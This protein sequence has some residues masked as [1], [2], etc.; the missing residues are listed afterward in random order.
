M[1][2][3]YFIG[4]DRAKTSFHC[5]IYQ[6]H[7]KLGSWEVDNHKQ[8]LRKLEKLLK[9][10]KITNKDQ[11][12]FGL[13]HTG[14]YNHNLLQWIVKK[15]YPLWLASPLAI[16]K[17]LGIQRGKSDQVDAQR[18]A[19][20]AARLADQAQLWQPAREVIAELKGL[21]RVRARLLEAR[22]KLKTPLRERSIFLSA[23]Q[24][25]RLS[26]CCASSL[27]H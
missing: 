19:Q 8:G 6:Q 2:Y 3:K 9:E 12:L 20:Y 21:V 11:A 17:S 13:A 7:N 4:I 23:A 5:C 18:I 15:G 16:K 10:L 27:K 22:H 26:C 14:V 25:K 1:D 24:Q